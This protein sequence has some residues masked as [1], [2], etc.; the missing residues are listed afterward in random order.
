[1]KALEEA[2]RVKT[3]VEKELLNLPGVTG[4]DVGS[5]IVAGN[6]TDIVAIR[7]YVKEKRDVPEGQAI[8]RQIRGIPT[9]VIE[10]RFVPHSS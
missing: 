9:D 8:P 3:E 10:R 2:R 5:K 4:V 6:K 7:V 1:M